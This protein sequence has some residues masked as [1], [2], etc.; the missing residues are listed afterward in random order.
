[1]TDAAKPK[2][3]ISCVSACFVLCIWHMA[4]ALFN[5]LYYLQVLVN[6]G[7]VYIID[8]LKQP[9]RLAQ[10]RIKALYKFTK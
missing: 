3:F 7:L 6:S 4:S 2:N 1:M 8:L 9:S 10:S 5:D